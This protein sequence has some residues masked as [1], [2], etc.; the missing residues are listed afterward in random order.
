[1]N[2]QWQVGLVAVLILLGPTGAWAQRFNAREVEVEIINERGREFPQYPLRRSHKGS[3]YKAHLEA[4]RGEKYAVRVR[5]RSDQRIGVV[6]AVDG[7]NIISGERS[8][9]RPD[10][11]MYVLEPY[12]QETY[13][14]WRTGKNRVNRFY[15]T[16]AGDSYAGAWGDYSAMGVIAVAAFREV[17][18]RQPQ[19][20]PW[21]EGRSDDRPRRGESSRPGAP[22]AAADAPRSLGAAPGTGYGEQE[23][24]PS[25]RV[26][27]EPE[28]RPFAQ[29]FLKYA[30]RATLCRQGVIDCKRGSH[31]YPRNRFWD[32]DNDRYAP[33][34]PR[35]DRH[36]REE[37]R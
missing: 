28:Q 5:N 37:W 23:W 12:E 24:S 8:D 11:R 16:D 3:I 20:Q 15:F 36:D 27:F 2:K 6:I 7:R 22:P 10:E 29:F 19:P 18:Y 25:R 26:E 33:P 34:P 21:A 32:E 4:V 14:G 17:V 35:H 9:L 1:M 31:P 30:W 13:E